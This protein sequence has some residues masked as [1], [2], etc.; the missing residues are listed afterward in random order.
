MTDE[1]EQRQRIY[2]AGA[3][4]MSD[5]E[6]TATIAELDDVIRRSEECRAAL[7]YERFD[8]ARLRDLEQERA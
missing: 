7:N 5:E 4:G 2:L 6:L 8:R 3:K 1:H